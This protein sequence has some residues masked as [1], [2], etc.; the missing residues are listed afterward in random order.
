MSGA[1]ELDHS[2]V[3]VDAAVQYH[4]DLTVTALEVNESVSAPTLNSTTDL[5]EGN[6]LYYTD[7]R[8]QA[9]SV[10][11]DASGTVGSLSVSDDSH[12]HTSS[13]ITLAS[14]DLTDSSSLIYDSD[15]S[16]T[17]LI[18]REGSQSYSIVSLVNGAYLDSGFLGVRIEATNLFYD[19]SSGQTKINTVQD[20]DI[21]AAPLF[22]GLRIAGDIICTGTYNGGNTTGS[23]LHLATNNTATKGNYFFD[24]LT[25]NGIIRTQSGTGE[26]T[27]DTATYLTGNESITLSGDVSGSGTTSITVT[28]T[29][30]SH[31]HTASTISLDTDDVTEATNLYFTNERVDDRVAAL[32][33]DSATVT[34]AYDDTAGTLTATSLGSSRVE[35]AFSSQSSVVV[36]HNFGSKPLVQV[37]SNDAS[38]VVLI[39][40]EITHNSVNQFTVLFSS[41]TSGS[42]IAIN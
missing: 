3:E 16:G 13:T 18:Q 35:Q 32:I 14:T 33:Q 28:V 36:T 26:L 11:G 8:V 9:V 29:D 31:S 15:F 20:I 40:N 30:D 39:P 10:G 25:T 27:V 42:I 12:D 4:K 5:P 19:T 21:T 41:A 38:P 23:S 7:A 1:Y 22:S 34:W 37:V 6:N 24:E 17:G 2:G